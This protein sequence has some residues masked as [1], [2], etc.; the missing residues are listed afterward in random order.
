VRKAPIGA[1]IVWL[2]ISAAARGEVKGT[3]EQA[4]EANLQ[5]GSQIRMRLQTGDF[6]ITG[7]DKPLFRVTCESSYG[8]NAKN[9]SIAYDAGELRISGGPKDGIRFRIE[10]P[11]NTNLFIRS[12]HGDI[13]ISGVTGDKDIELRSGD[14]TI[15]AGNPA[16]YKHADASVWAGNVDAA[17]FAV[18]RDGVLKR[19]KKDNAAG[20]YSLHVRLWTGDLTLR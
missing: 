15:D 1:A 13:T 7:N 5:A 9:V 18:D 17:P 11:K 2:A 14:V 8:G 19:F 4:V 3:C 6:S 10:V 16:D 12:R 20:K